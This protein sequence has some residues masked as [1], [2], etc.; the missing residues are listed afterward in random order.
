MVNAPHAHTVNLEEVTNV[1]T[2]Q[3]AYQAKS[4]EL[5]IIV[6]NAKLASYL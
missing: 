3:P 4:L 2:L 5:Q 6:I 1:S